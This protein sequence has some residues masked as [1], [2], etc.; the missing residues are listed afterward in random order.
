VGTRA[1]SGELTAVVV[2]D[3]EDAGNMLENKEGMNPWRATTPA[4]EL[5]TL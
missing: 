3:K 1:Q 4:S 2:T 5:S